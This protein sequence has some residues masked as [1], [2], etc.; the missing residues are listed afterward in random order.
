MTS[1]SNARCV[2]KDTKLTVITP[3][4]HEYVVPFNQ[5]I[6]AV[7]PIADGIIIQALHLPDQLY[8]QP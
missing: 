5:D 2:F 6:V 1:H 7:H 4:G 8:F 3:G